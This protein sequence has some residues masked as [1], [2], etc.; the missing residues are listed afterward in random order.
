MAAAAAIVGPVLIGEGAGFV[1]EDDF[2]GVIAVGDVEGPGEALAG[3]EA[4]YL[5]RKKQ[6]WVRRWRGKGWLGGQRRLRWDGDISV[7][8]VGFWRTWMVEG[9]H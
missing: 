3:F 9:W 2:D 4:I 8:V 7:A 5:S 6:W 1:V